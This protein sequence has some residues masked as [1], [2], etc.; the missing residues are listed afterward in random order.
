MVPRTFFV[1]LQDDWFTNRFIMVVYENFYRPQ[2]SCSNVMFFTPV[3]QSF[4]SQGVYPSMHWDR[5]LP[6]QTYPSMHWGRHPPGGDGYCCR[7]YTSYWNAFLSVISSVMIFLSKPWLKK[8]HRQPL[9]SYQSEMTALPVWCS[10][11]CWLP[12]FLPLRLSIWEGTLNQ[13]VVRSM[14]TIL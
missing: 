2:H 9:T 5:Y 6:G 8:I 13:L 7:R 11:L 1:L 4:C 3:C 14:S 10:I 12:M